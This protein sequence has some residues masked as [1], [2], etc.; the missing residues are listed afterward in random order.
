MLVSLVMSA[1]LPQAY[2][3]RGLAVGVA[4]AVMQV[5]RSAFAVAGLRGEALQRNF[6]RILAWCVVSGTLAVLGGVAH[7]HARPLLWLGAV[8]VDFLGGVVAFY[9]PGLGRSRTTDWPVDGGHFAERCQA[10]LIIAL[11][12]SIVVIGATLADLPSV[13]TAQVVAFCAAFFG[14]VALWWLYFDRSA[15]AGAAVIAASAD[16]G[17]LSRSAY[18]QIHPIMVA[19]IIVTA[20]ADERVLSHPLASVDPSAALLVLGGPA[21]FLAGHA[22]F[23]ATVWRIVPWTRLAAIA[24]LG[25]LGLVAAGTNGV[26]LGVL[27]GVVVVAVAATDRLATHD[28]EVSPSAVPS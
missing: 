20:A 18:H 26:T 9:T 2:G 6:Q 13:A 7:G 5:G 22:A 17:R 4:Y 21:L 16:P 3:D 14:S 8:A 25:L 11:G 28:E 10:F 27:T 15:E 23:K 1:A 19:G 24:V 12:E